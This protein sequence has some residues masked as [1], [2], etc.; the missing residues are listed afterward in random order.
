MA[1]LQ[2]TRSSRH[3]IAAIATTAAAL[4]FC[5]PEF[6]MADV[7]CQVGCYPPLERG[8]NGTTTESCP[9]DVCFYSYSSTTTKEGNLI[10]TYQCGNIVCPQLGIGCTEVLSAR[11]C[12][13][14]GNQCNGKAITSSA[15]TATA[16]G[17]VPILAILTAAVYLLLP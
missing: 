15:S 11:A 16:T 7:L 6:C 13:C 8:C 17:L 1:K 4:L 3:F 5:L 12:C 14:E 10:L 9:G 2:S